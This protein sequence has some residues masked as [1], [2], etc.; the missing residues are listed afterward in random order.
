MVHQVE[1]TILNI[2]TA[3]TQDIQLKKEIPLDLK[4]HI[5]INPVTVVDFNTLL[6]KQVI[7]AK[8][9]QENPG[10]KKHTKLNGPNISTKHP[11]KQ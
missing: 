10:I 3:K 5:N 2:Y 4:P 9:K 8:T 1:I 6:S 7:W 11:T